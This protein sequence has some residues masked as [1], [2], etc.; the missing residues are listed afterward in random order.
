MAVFNGAFPVLAGKVDAIRAFAEETMGAQLSGFEEAQRRVDSTRETWSIQQLPD[1]SAIILVW[2]ETQNVEAVFTDLAH[3][4]SEW[5][6]WFRGRVLEITG[7]DLT[8]PAPGAP[9]LI[10]DWRA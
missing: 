4:D 8:Q 9:E 5:T 1:G 3:D 2:V 10:L 6:V 7:I